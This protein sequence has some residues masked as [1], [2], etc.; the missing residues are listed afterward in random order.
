MKWF[1]HFSMKKVLTSASNENDLDERN[2][3][4]TSFNQ[5]ANSYIIIG[6]EL[7]GRGKPHISFNNKHP[8]IPAAMKMNLPLP[9]RHEIEGD[10]YNSGR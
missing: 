7:L 8:E 4:E 9:L 6:C 10:H 2:S 5:I 3:V 1:E